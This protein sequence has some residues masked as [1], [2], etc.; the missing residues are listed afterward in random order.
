MGA[1]GRVVITLDVGA[2]QVEI[3]AALG[4]QA[5]RVHLDRFFAGCHRRHGGHAGGHRLQFGRDRLA[6]QA[7]VHAQGATL[8][9]VLARRNVAF[10]RAGGKQGREQESGRQGG[11][12]CGIFGGLENVA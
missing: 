1:Q 6:E 10:G 12:H 3:D 11:A 4:A 7:G 8:R 2:V 9:N 5:D